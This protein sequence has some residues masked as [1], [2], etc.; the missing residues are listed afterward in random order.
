MNKG[1]KPLFGRSGGRHLLVNLSN[2][3]TPREIENRRVN[4]FLAS[5]VIVNG[6]NV[7]FRLLADFPN[8]G[9]A[10]AVFGEH[11]ACRLNEALPRFESFLFDSHKTNYRFK[12]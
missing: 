11:F 10:E 6:G 2:R 7:G 8:G 4:L 1:A 9:V 5:E 3:A 12:R